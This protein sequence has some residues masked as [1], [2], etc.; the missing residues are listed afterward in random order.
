MDLTNGNAVS[1]SDQLVE[2][3]IRYCYKVSSALLTGAEGSTFEKF[4]ELNSSAIKDFAV[5]RSSSVLYLIA[6]PSENVK[7][8]S[9][10][11]VGN[12]EPDLLNDAHNRNVL[13]L[14]KSQPTLS[15]E[16]ALESQILVLS[17]A[18]GLEMKAFN[19]VMAL[20]VTTL[21]ECALGPQQ[22]MNTD[23]GSLQNMRLKIDEFFS[24]MKNVES[25]AVAPNLLLSGDRLIKD[26]VNRGATIENFEEFL[27]DTQ[28]ADSVFLNSLQRIVNG[29]IHSAE[30]FSNSM[31]SI[32]DGDAK[33]EVSFWQKLEQGML[34]IQDQL[35]SS[36]AKITVEILKNSR[37]P[38]A[39]FSLL[40][41]S[42][43]P[44][45]LKKVKSYNQFLCEL[46]MKKLQTAVSL[47]TLDGLID[48][49]ATAF[50]R[51]R[52]SL[53]PISRAQAL[54]EQIC[55]EVIC[56][57]K[58]LV[59]QL[60][61]LPFGEYESKTKALEGFL[62][63][64][65]ELIESA[66]LIM[67]E[68]TRRRSEKYV[69]IKIASKTDLL[70]HRLSGI[71]K[72]RSTYEELS[73]DLE[74]PDMLKY[75]AEVP[76][77]YEPLKTTDCLSC[78]TEQWYALEST[79]NQRL[80]IL[81]NK[82]LNA[83]LFKLHLCES[84]NEMFTLLE[85]FRSL[86]SRPR[87]RKGIQ[88]Y[89]GGLLKAVVGELSNLKQKL[90][91]CN[92]DSNAA[93]LND[94][95]PVSSSLMR[96]KLLKKRVSTIL[97]KLT[98]LL[99][100][101]WSSSEDG[102]HLHSE[103]KS[104][105]EG[106]NEDTIVS[107]W[108][109]KASCSEV[110]LQEPIFKVLKNGG[111]YA[112]F[113]N[114]N[115]E[116][117]DL[118]KEVRNLC[119]MGYDLPS[120]LFKA[121]TVLRDL[122]PITIE[123]MEL[124]DT[125][126][127]ITNVV[128]ERPA[129]NALL[130]SLIKRS[131]VA[132]K[133]CINENWKAISESEIAATTAAVLDFDENPASL[134]IFR[135]LVNEIITR[136]NSLESL[137]RSLTSF[138][139]SIDL[140]KFSEP[141]LRNWITQIV[142]LKSSITSLEKGNYTCFE[143]YLEAQIEESVLNLTRLA[144]KPENLPKTKHEVTIDSNGV[145]LE[146]SL[147]STKTRWLQHIQNTLNISFTLKAYY[148]DD[149]G[150]PVGQK[151]KRLDEFKIQVQRYAMSASTE[152]ESLL[153]SA[154]I[155]LRSLNIHKVLWRPK[156]QI[157]WHQRRNDILYCF[158]LY[159]DFMK[160]RSKVKSMG[161]RVKL[162]DS[163]TISLKDFQAKI[164]S[165]YEDWN[166]EL[167]SELECQYEKQSLEF[168]STLSNYRK[169][170]ESNSISVESCSL[171]ELYEICSTIENLNKSWSHKEE[172]LSTLHSVHI[173]MREN[174]QSSLSEVIQGDQLDLDMKLLKQILEK[175]QAWLAERKF[176]IAS[177][178]EMWNDKLLKSASSFREE[179]QICKPVSQDLK[180][181]NALEILEL[182]EHAVSLESKNL[183]M[184][185]EISL[186]LSIPVK[187]GFSLTDVAADIAAYKIA[188]DAISIRWASLKLYLNTPWAQSDLNNLKIELQRLA[189]EQHENEGSL[190]N[191]VVFKAFSENIQGILNSIKLLNTLKDKCM[192]PRHWKI[193]F[194]EAGGSSPSRDD[195]DGMSFILEDVLSLKQGLNEGFVSEVIKNAKSEEVVE[196]SL[197]DIESRWRYTKFLS[198]HHA[199]NF[200]I[201]KNW[202]TLMQSITDDTNTL[203]A[204]KNS[205]H[206]KVFEQRSV[207][208]EIK[209]NE[210]ALILNSWAESQ[211]LWLH[212]YGALGDSA[213]SSNFLRSESAR[214]E[215]IT[216]EF[217]SIASTVLQSDLVLD[218]LHIMDLSRSLRNILESLKRVVGALNGYLESQRER[219]P[220]LYFLGN[221]DLLQLMGASQ[222][223]Y[224]ASHHLGKIYGGVS[225]LKFED[226]EI[227]GVSSPEGETLE[228]LEPILLSKYPE[229]QEWVAQ[230]GIQI[231]SSIMSST[232]NC[233][234]KLKVSGV[235]ELSQLFEQHVF[236]AL[237]LSFQI[238]W[239]SIIEDAISQ[240]EIS[241]KLNEIQTVFNK[242]NSLL[243]DTKSFLRRRK[244]ES[245]IVECIHY[246]SLS[247]ELRA[248]DVA[249][250]KNIWNSIPKYYH[251]ASEY[252]MFQR[253]T[254]SI[255]NNKFSHGL[256]YIG[257]PERLIYTP[258][259]RNCFVAMA[260]ALA[261]N[262][263]GS[264]FGP[265]GTGKTETIKA[266][267]QNLGRF[268]LVFNCDESFEFQSL[269]RLLLGIGQVGAWGCF[270]EFNRLE[271]SIMSA[272]STQIETIQDALAR[273]QE[274]FVL[275]R[276]TV[277]LDDSTGI[278]I[279]MN[280]GYKGRRELPDNLRKK[281]RQ[282]SMKSP[283][284]TIIADVILTT[285]GFENAKNMAKK[286]CNFL[287]EMECLCSQQR[288]YDFGLRAMK[289]ILRNCRVLKNKHGGT[290]QDILLESL[291]QML[292]PR[293]VKS[294]EDAFCKTTSALFPNTHLNYNDNDFREG[295]EKVCQ[296]GNKTPTD[297]FVKKCIQLF[298]I[299]N[300]QQAIILSGPPGTGKTTIWNSTLDC[301]ELADGIKN[302]VFLID[303]KVLTKEQL[304]GCLDP[305]TFEWTDGVFTSIIRKVAQDQ[306]EK[307]NETRIWIIFDGDLDPEYVETINSVLDDNKV[308][309]LP[310]G[311]RFKIPDNLRL[312]FEVDDLDIATPATIS[313]CAVIVIDRPVCS[314]SEMLPAL[315]VEK[316]HDMQIASRLPM[317]FLDAFCETSYD[318]LGQKLHD[319]HD[320][321]K[322]LPNAMDTSLLGSLDNLVSLT[323]SQLFQKSES[324]QKLSKSS[325]SNFA[326]CLLC[327][328]IVW[329]ITGACN[330][331]DRSTFEQYMR[332]GLGIEDLASNDSL[333]LTDYEAI[334]GELKLRPLSMSMPQITLEPHEV[335]LPD[336]MIPTVDTMKH[337]RLILDLLYAGKSPILCGPPGSG[338][339]MTIFN[340]LKNSKKFDL[341]GLTFSKET[342]VASFLDT[343]K[344]H[345]TITETAKGILLKPKSLSKD[346]VVFCDEINLPEAD[347]YGAQPVIL[348]LRQLLEKKG[349]WD[350]SSHRW[351]SLERIHVAGACNPPDNGS[352]KAL[353]E[354]FTRHTSVISID[355]PGKNSLLHIYEVFFKAVLKLAP[356]LRGYSKEFAHAS[357]QLYY[358]CKERFSSTV[359]SHYIYS[360][361][362]LTRLIK[363][364]YYILTN[365]SIRA[366]SQLIECWVYECLRLYS[367]R[368]VC[369]EDK[370]AFD[371]IIIETTTE[372][373]PNQIENYYEIRDNLLCNWVS[374]EYEKTDRR[375]LSFFVRERLKTFNEEELES[376]LIVH[377]SMLDH[378]V[379]IDRALKQDQGHCILVGPS[380]SGK[381]SL[382]RFVS[383]M[384]GIEVIPLTLHRN[385]H[386]SDFDKF[387]R[388]ILSRCTA[389]GQKILL[390]IDDSSILE[391]SFIE[392][393]NT[394]LANSDVPGLFE[395]EERTKL[396]ADL[397]Q[398]AEE[399]GLL[400][401]EDEELYSWFT[402]LIS[403]NLHVVFSIND[404]NSE[405]ATNVI[406]SPALF[407]R[408]VLNWMGEWSDQTLAQVGTKII[409]WMP[410]SSSLDGSDPEML[411]KSGTATP[412]SKKIVDVAILF[413]K[414]FQ[415]LNLGRQA[416][417]GQF[418]DQLKTFQDIYSRK[419]SE[420]E[421]SQRFIATGLDTMKE[422]VLRI[423]ELNEL[424]SEKEKELRSKEQQGRKTLDNML[425]T[426]NEAERRH[427]ATVEIRKI[428]SAQEKE[429]SSQRARIMSD[430]ASIE[431]QVLE[432]QRGVN[433]I[434]KQHMTE[435][436]SM[437]N[438]PNNVKLT[439]EAV[440][441]ILGYHSKEWRDI[442]SFVRKDEFISSIVQYDT[443]MMMNATIRD[444][445]KKEYLMKPGFN[446]EAV[447]H[448]SKA[449]GPLFQWVVAQVEYSTILNTISPLK[450]DV[451]KIE[452]EMIQ[453]KARLLAS[454]DMIS[455]Y[456]DLM[457]SSKR[458]YSN[459]IRETEA[460][461]AELSAVEHKVSRSR[462]LLDSLAS[463]NER[464]SSSTVTFKELR[465][466]IVGDC[467]L[468][469]LFISYCGAKDRKTR[470]ELISSWK[471]HLG[472]L[473]V[474]YD[475]N[476]TFCNHLV[477]FQERSRWFSNGLPDD[478][479]CIENFY[480]LF[481]SLH[482]PFVVDPELKVFHALR[483]HFGNTIAMTS[484]L[485]SGFVKKLE[486]ML[487]FG[488]CIII[489][490]GEF[491]DPIISK[492][493]AKEFRK[494]GG[495]ETIQ[496]GD[497]DIDI[498]P[499]FFM[500]IFTR[501]ASWSI[502]LFL[503]ARMSIVD[504]TV[505][506]NSIEPQALEIALECQKP[507]L[508][509]K[510]KA[511]AQL[512][513]EY[514]LRLSCLEKE[515]LEALNS[516]P[517]SVLENESLITTLEQLKTQSNEI[518][519][520]ILETKGVIEE[521]EQAVNEFRAL[522]QH[523]FRL[524]SIVEHLP[525]LHWAYQVTV[526]CFLNC[527]RSIFNHDKGCESK[528]TNQ[529]LRSFYR[530][531]FE[532][533][534]PGLLDDDKL[535]L[536]VMLLVSYFEP[537]EPSAFCEIL[538]QLMSSIRTSPKSPTLNIQL[539]FESAE[540]KTY[541]Q[542]LIEGFEDFD[543]YHRL[544]AAVEFLP[545][546][547][548]Y[549]LK[550][551]V[552]EWDY[553][554]IVIV[555]ER[556]TD[557][558]YRVSQL[559]QELS[560]E[561]S[562]VSL[563]S[564]ESTSM[565]EYA[566]S[567]CAKEG[568][569]LLIQN[570]Q[571]SPDWVKSVLTKR[572]ELLASDTNKS[573]S[574]RVFMTCELEGRAPPPPLIQTSWKVVH[575]S[576]KGIL[577]SARDVWGTISRPGTIRPPEKLFCRFLLA[578]FHALLVENSRLH[579]LGFTKKYDF[580]DSDFAAGIAYL[581][582][583]FDCLSSSHN[584]IKPADISWIELQ[585]NIATIIYGG[586]IDDEKDI[587]RCIELAAGLFN[588][589]AF[590][591][592]FEIAPGL[593]APQ[594]RQEWTSIQ[595]WLVQCRPP[596]NW[597][598]W[599]QL[600]ENVELERRELHAA[601]V[602]SS[603][604]QILKGL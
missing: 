364:L 136:F 330:E 592:D 248:F 241:P 20:G 262:L 573:S 219:F 198:A 124:L 427:E 272:V 405:S 444:F 454:E 571:M 603:V 45:R 258:L 547:E 246:L 264:P 320:F 231:K 463:E 510:R 341:I 25:W 298:Q 105:L 356:E 367:D 543:I 71:K 185:N 110:L 271:E 349:Y 82:I 350:V 521:V 167:L 552:K 151:T 30:S 480:I 404:P 53:F 304:Y 443:E 354:R 113:V 587:L 245:L 423:R 378:M 345:T 278:F 442:Q 481:N 254:V 122:Y 217:S 101:D 68:V 407:N 348:L 226:K 146:P 39:A 479:T 191:Q 143:T 287:T 344:H 22:L 161:M 458:E 49:F 338:K 297:L 31:R 172:I 293:L 491:Y 483:R 352:R 550:E 353:S 564:S 556:G 504:F 86:L 276:K 265:A 312:I 130:G 128:N 116:F 120:S 441:L 300:S 332:T 81:E 207:S 379:R 266:L 467:L 153:Q 549:Q 56:K 61:S 537:A 163:L 408:C 561:L 149:K 208:W 64:W 181:E 28:F 236:Q 321:A 358:S 91:D 205:S 311:E 210:L 496:I 63:R 2:E 135:S 67:R 527:F 24:S 32:D 417:P 334:A 137:E 87:L 589:R 140:T 502:P 200:V 92:G 85:K 38:Q 18:Q 583:F 380:R 93:A 598:Q 574:F 214:F 585:F 243:K 4:Q 490:D 188:W 508:H 533:L 168:H 327:I 17:M 554:P 145:L 156:E 497:R 69:P 517:N 484:F 438:P 584:S 29:W 51:L 399:I 141:S 66:T 422:S 396:I 555:C 395:A 355:Y 211:R 389:G 73:L 495:K 249:G 597:S 478:Y 339:T 230:I 174:N 461:K 431:P 462:K 305:V 162:S 197:E 449:C 430:L 576:E 333:S 7:A 46:P 539:D 314:P 242:L 58:K 473:S 400:L 302:K 525:S 16:N 233:L 538:S 19:Q 392:R 536:G 325:F 1:S 173:L 126:I 102:L 535:A 472:E 193:L 23:N 369:D 106:L 104:I 465:Q 154:C 273:K 269:G 326:K 370:K 48:A 586:K 280:R 77:I 322:T 542:N 232:E 402:Q 516:S 469:S 331:D 601:N 499:N 590:E 10:P 253:I 256:E 26:I 414:N 565:A 235:Q 303:L 437:F 144:L 413:F 578:W 329:A 366:L 372:Y 88:Q 391:S 213:S 195:I 544:Q 384:N 412:L 142:S 447:N 373:F 138:L 155:L 36:E 308:L 158:D 385:F 11:D 551:F 21:I 277:Y 595:E 290:D 456:R 263:G 57:I 492:L 515:L 189:D 274:K 568:H 588:E 577:Q 471:K 493:I 365:S 440:C 567:H 99:G 133:H 485:D 209:F 433:N 79:C 509:E 40:A 411:S 107:E 229:M 363:G 12:S 500:V 518:Q 50:K 429:L 476:Y 182:K 524:Y 267:G 559:A 343:L 531:I 134:S 250:R 76:F 337:E 43:V 507:E 477:D 450:N 8:S 238:R 511:L 383:W 410:L 283:D 572:L 498:D 131:W 223:L 294:D 125:F 179:W 157:I 520:R 215:M 222:N 374:L 150:E 419:I 292:S 129:L 452:K 545:P 14:I 301:M 184:V 398:K 237:L 505:D 351:V 323:C 523:A 218:V 121:S 475:Q 74:N 596:E 252:D 513:G 224:Q 563:G 206:Y 346:L 186:F 317:S 377:D 455:D 425:S 285:L 439:L 115:R 512:N 97:S 247:E 257:V 78:S 259:M 316:L 201:V 147:E 212:L 386:I 335:I 359:Y 27:P 600:A 306:I 347:E 95:P 240:D 435:I 190:A 310:N 89:H 270:D 594:N 148:E 466:N 602:A 178:I 127:Q 569:W 37:R 519:G 282:F 187:Q 47:P 275:L 70:R 486:N 15:L 426:Q 548:S 177:R 387:L 251:N 196:Q 457:E 13:A 357:V 403:R 296:F 421:K 62:S 451:A 90:L 394:L 239:T 482:Y 84:T 540:V 5:N 103:C 65:D 244:I 445:I 318:V 336:L 560:R 593:L 109:S 522:S 487:R 6:D 234:Q 582:G 393:M 558:T 488:G 406:N 111:G 117:R 33:D 216:S 204:M 286:I 9:S 397:S 255:G 530:R 328:N 227:L 360:P 562:I 284:Y 100:R 553:V 194:Q 260:H 388:N 42:T 295:V 289:G 169:L 176:I 192:K 180:P 165:C 514:K 324:V 309:T 528:N 221:E 432:A 532:V 52:T 44:E 415:V 35:Q 299:Q 579:P 506:K 416:T 123:F 474:S 225:S 94:L 381:R 464:W 60:A 375:E 434:K 171:D 170:L 368:L 96:I 494:T 420:L 315:L 108:Y 319:L 362:E 390:L 160:E 340:A 599:L 409:E 228:F 220:R 468:S 424:F 291:H 580:N 575:E 361:R 428:L 164:E 80:G 59:P 281:F 119:W 288:H 175:R 307:H 376:T 98:L 581:D 382:T 557:S 436:R 75:K 152:V 203:T 604:I 72:L 371:K 114:S 3:A 526:N 55:V 418:L 132:L 529:L 139:N 459:I 534:S 501:D 183:E 489:Q 503:R 54:T 541:T 279:T 34:S 448:A 546:A 446:F 591:P 41:S 112:I 460:I 268:V 202:N 570:L 118:F 261:Q 313:R 566:L 166:K 199:G 342:T 470:L 83:L 453:T 401:D 159:S